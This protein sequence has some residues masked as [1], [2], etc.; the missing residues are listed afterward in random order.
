MA[1]T[2][3][4]PA[5]PGIITGST[6]VTSGQTNLLYSI[7]SIVGL[8][9]N[10]TVPA[11]AT[12]VSGQGTGKLTVNWGS[13]SGNVSVSAH[14][15]C[16]SSPVRSLAV[17]VV[18]G[19]TFNPKDLSSWSNYV[20]MYPNP[21]TSTLTVA[22]TATT[23]N[24]YEAQIVNSLGQVLTSKAGYTVIGINTVT[25][26]MTKYASAMY[27]VRLL[28]KEHGTRILKMVKAK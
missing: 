21:V 12:I 22:F 10:W 8:T 27:Y 1:V 3:S 13:T 15:A 16:G 17:T 7:K 19:F 24:K 26:D 2:A 20:G 28:D 5:E 9:Y 25:F 23:E 14:N 4:A 18:A 11:G 6:S